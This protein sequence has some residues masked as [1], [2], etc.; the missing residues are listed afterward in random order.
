M[1]SHISQEEK[2]RHIHCGVRKTVRVHSA[3]IPLSS[4]KYILVE[5]GPDR[6]ISIDESGR[7]AL[8][9]PTVFLTPR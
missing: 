5:A 8:L 6:S 3:T 7:V 1:K 4:V 2:I 9:T